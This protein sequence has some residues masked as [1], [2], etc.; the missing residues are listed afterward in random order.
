MCTIDHSCVREIKILQVIEM[1]AGCHVR[2]LEFNKVEAP[3]LLDKE[4]LLLLVEH[5]LKRRE[6]SLKCKGLLAEPF[7]VGTIE[8]V[9]FML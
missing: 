4:K 5:P 9:N 2:K 6:R 1:R 3:I 8:D 7:P